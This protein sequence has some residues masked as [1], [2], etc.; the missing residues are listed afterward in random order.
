MTNITVSSSVHCYLHVAS[1]FTLRHTSS[2]HLYSYQGFGW[3]WVWL[4]S[5]QSTCIP[6]MVAIGFRFGFDLLPPDLSRHHTI[7][8]MV[9]V[10]LLVLLCYIFS[11]YAKNT[12]IKPWSRYCFRF[13]VWL[14]SCFFFWGRATNPNHD[15]GRDCWLVFLSLLCPREV[16]H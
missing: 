15:L 8:T 9:P 4:A 3:V 14:T 5:N 10:S 12:R 13:C 16:K 11:T 2:H 7:Q 1:W 6:T